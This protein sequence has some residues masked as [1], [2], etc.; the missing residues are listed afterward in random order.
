MSMSEDDAA[1]WALE[2]DPANPEQWLA[3]GR[4]L[5]LEAKGSASDPVVQ[6][7]ARLALL[8][9]AEFGGH[10]A[11]SSFELGR[12]LEACSE[13]EVASRAYIRAATLDP[14]SAEACERAAAIF[15]HLG[16]EE[17]V[18]Y[19]VN[20]G[21]ARLK[22]GARAFTLTSFANS[23]L[24]VG[25]SSRAVGVLE[26]L[27][28]LRP[29]DPKAHCY[30]SVALRK[31]SLVER[32]VESA[33]RA[34]ELAPD[35][36]EP[37]LVLGRNLEATRRVV[38]AREAYEE[39]MARGPSTDARNQTTARLMQLESDEAKTRLKQLKRAAPQ[40]ASTDGTVT[41]DLAVFH[42]PE[43]LQVLQLQAAT[44]Q[45]HLRKGADSVRI[46]FASGRITG[47]LGKDGREVVATSEA[48]S[49][50]PAFVEVL[51]PVVGWQIGHFEFVSGEP[52]SGQTS[53][54]DTQ[55][56][57]M[58]V[59]RSLDERYRG[60]NLRGEFVDRSGPGPSQSVELI[61]GR[62]DSSS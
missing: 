62:K 4:Q 45:L 18:E 51:A 5:L 25:R 14:R 3:I 28:R 20:E 2:S 38:E 56:L 10:D 43:L 26:Q 27:V 54:Y 48:E 61:T 40:T 15:A 53:G 29:D 44:G 39:G 32:S 57:L 41:G 34:V 59:L 23:L 19:W 33:R 60:Y 36:A 31:A 37:Y 55:F 50:V 11:V 42:V 17:E 22:P 47:A 12:L 49:P 8:A 30:L 52:P 9:A 46:H 7:S 58:E 13:F 24:R 6:A 35:D 1:Y 16:R 21:Q